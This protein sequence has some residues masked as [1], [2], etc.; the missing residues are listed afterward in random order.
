[1]VALAILK[2]NDWGE[3]K[4]IPCPIFSNGQWVERPDNNRQILLWEN[5]DRDRI[6]EDFYKTLKNPV[7]VAVPKK[8]SF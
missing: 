6:M 1:M 4:S 3:T 2:N 5:F 8:D 7:P